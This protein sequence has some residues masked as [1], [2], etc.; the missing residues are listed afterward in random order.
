[1]IKREPDADS[2]IQWVYNDHKLRLT[3]YGDQSM[4][5]GYA[6]CSHSSLRLFGKKVIGASIER[7]LDA[8]QMRKLRFVTEEYDLWTSYFNEAVWLS[9]HVEYQCVT[10]VE[11]G[12][13]FKSDEEY[14]WPKTI[15]SHRI[16][17]ATR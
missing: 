17:K 16:R 6:R 14:N 9:L 15:L 1:M 8:P 11:V 3:F 10:G 13:P 12:V 2:N 7:I 4:R 5:L